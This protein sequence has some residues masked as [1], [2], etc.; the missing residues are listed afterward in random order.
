MNFPTFYQCPRAHLALPPLMSLCVCVCVLT[1]R[2]L[3]VFAEPCLLFLFPDSLRPPERT[4]LEINKHIRG[5]GFPLL[6]VCIAARTA[7]PIQS[8]HNPCILQDYI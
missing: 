3:F 7:K 1:L 2:P 4:D 6:Q 8:P 5:E